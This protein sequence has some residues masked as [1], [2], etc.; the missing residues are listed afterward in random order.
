MRNLSRRRFMQGVS[1]AA[2]GLAASSCSKEE[3]DLLPSMLADR[4]PDGLLEIFLLGGY[5]PWDTFYVIPE[6]GDPRAGGPYAGQQWW[7]FQ[8]ESECA[9]PWDGEH[10]GQSNLRGVC[11]GS[12][13]GR[14]PIVGGRT[15]PAAF[16]RCGGGDRPLLEPW[17]TDAAGKMAHL[18]PFIYPLRDRPDLLKRLRVWVMTH[19]VDS[20]DGAIPIAMT[21]TTRGNP[22]MASLGAHIQAHYQSLGMP[23]QTSPLAY[24]IYHSSMDVTDNSDAATAVGLH[25]ASARPMRIRLGSADQLYDRLQRSSVAG[26]RQSLD[27][28][29]R[30]YIERLQNRMRTPAGADLRAPTLTDLAAARATLEQSDLIAKLLDPSVLAVTPAA[31]CGSGPE[32]FL[33]LLPGVRY[34]D[35]MPDET[36]TALSLATRLLNSTESPARFV[37]IIDGGLYPLPGGRGYDFHGDHAMMG[38]ANLVHFFR[39]L[40]E[41][42]NEPG[43]NDPGKLDLDRHM[44]ILNTEF[45]RT[46]YP[47]FTYEIPGT[48]HWPY[49]YVIVG[50]GGP[51]DEERSGIVG[52]LGEDSRPSTGG[53][54]PAEHR[55]AMLLAMGVPPFGPNGFAVGE[56]PGVA[57]RAEATAHLLEDVLGYPA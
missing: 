31:A 32:L 28:L 49:G 37:N 30:H 9:F 27:D 3:E 51:I 10:T 20:H 42:I 25:P 55:A 52:A 23:G 16:Q 29:A 56:I 8:P 39:R 48:N 19:G 41:H 40:A 14:S 45:G 7:L 17:K 38:A 46:P 54:T 35:E 50:L 43:E 57:D 2:V 53:L 18:G 26:H 1:A 21:G 15:I 36:N 13:S 34:G 5:S 44:I 4:R 12:G 33:D 6:H 11:D 24:S 47:E 22:R